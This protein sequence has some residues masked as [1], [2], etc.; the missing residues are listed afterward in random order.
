MTNVSLIDG[1]IDLPKQADSE[2][3]HA[4]KKAL[5]VANENVECLQEMVNAL[6]N[7]QETLQ[8]RLDEKNKEIAEYKSQIRLLE[9]RLARATKKETN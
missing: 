8:K 5:R 6:I 9:G 4:M 7:G 2:I 1:H 3:I